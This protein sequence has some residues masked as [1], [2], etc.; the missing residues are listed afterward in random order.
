MEVACA[1]APAAVDAEAGR[2]AAP[3][4]RVFVTGSHVRQRVD[5]NTG[6]PLPISPIRIYSREQLIGTGQPDLR[7]ALGRLDPT[8]SP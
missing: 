5:P 3:L 8:L 4:E 6:M 1:H 2:K 7:A